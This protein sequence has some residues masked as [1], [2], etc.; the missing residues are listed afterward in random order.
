MCNAR[1]ISDHIAN[2]TKV[3][4]HK[5]V[6]DSRIKSAL[7]GPAGTSVTPSA[8][9]PPKVK[10]LALDQA[11]PI[12]LK[13]GET[14][15]LHCTVSPA[16]APTSLKWKS[17]KKK[18]VTVSSSGLVTAVGDGAATVTVTASN[19]VK[20]SVKVTSVDPSAAR[21]VTLDRQGT[22]TVNV[23]ET[24]QLNATVAPENATAKLTWKSGKPRFATVSGS[25][26][27]T[28]IAKGTTK[29]TVTTPNKKKAVVTVKVLDP[30]P[31]SKVLLKEKGPRVL[32]VGETLQLNAV[33]TPGTAKTTYA[34]TSSKKGVA[35]V[36]GKGLVTA[37]KKGKTK[38]TVKT[39]NKKK[40]T[41]IIQVVD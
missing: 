8:P 1:W 35:K 18:N 26:L 22:V 13:K 12:T 2:G 16:D 29:I 7:G 23:G 37:V 40:A 39:A 33:L 31:P 14:L 27:V 11:G 17:S 15:Q 36:D 9:M 21:S 34:W 4:I 20:A 3:V 10:S 24:L 30:N 19:G 28:G 41:I 5:G 6:N 38:I 32:R 25:G